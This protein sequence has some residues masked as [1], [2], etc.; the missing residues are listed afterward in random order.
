MTVT[1]ISLARFVREPVIGVSEAEKT[2]A[3]QKAGRRQITRA[4]KALESNIEL[5]ERFRRHLES[6]SRQS[7]VTTTSLKGKL[8]GAIAATGAG[9]AITSVIPFTGGV[10]S[11]SQGTPWGKLEYAR[12]ASS[13]FRLA[14]L[15]FGVGTLIALGPYA[16]WAA[17]RVSLTRRLQRAGLRMTGKGKF[18]VREFQNGGELTKREHDRNYV[19]VMTALERNK[20]ALKQLNAPKQR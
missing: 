6:N 1:E 3:K 19:W 9:I 14:G 18:V 10:Y 15:M 17:N 20:K 4:R 5:L 8:G 7:A 12:Q 11:A 2:L 13:D 16:K